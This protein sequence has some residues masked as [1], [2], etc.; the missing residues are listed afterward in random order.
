[1]LCADL[2]VVH[3]VG[4]ANRFRPKCLDFMAHLHRT[5]RKETDFFGE[6]IHNRG[7]SLRLF[8][9]SIFRNKWQKKNCTTKRDRT[10]RT[11]KLIAQIALNWDLCVC[12]CRAHRFKFDFIMYREKQ[13]F[14]REK[15]ICH[16]LL[17]AR[18]LLCCQKEKGRK[19]FMFVRGFWKESAM[20]RRMCILNDRLH[21]T[22][23][24]NKTA[25]YFCWHFYVEIIGFA[26]CHRL[27]STHEWDEEKKTNIRM[28]D[29]LAIFN[30][31]PRYIFFSCSLFI[32]ISTAFLWVM[33]SMTT[34]MTHRMNR[35]K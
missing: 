35:Q 16:S 24:N 3:C 30:E 1:M 14:P 32:H 27:G 19:C 25:T 34:R 21:S 23:A 17:L 5:N 8:R 11:N 2:K 15:K 18:L 4:S 12:L 13:F 6:N 9:I 10:E 22:I 26:L 29:N 33:W 31:S 7:K 20:F 28:R